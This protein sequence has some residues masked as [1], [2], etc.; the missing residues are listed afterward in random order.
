MQYTWL[1]ITLQKNTVGLV[2]K[3]SCLYLQLYQWIS[4]YTYTLYLQIVLLCRPPKSISR[5]K[6][7]PVH[8]EDK[9][10]NSASSSISATTTGI[11]D[12]LS[13]VKLLQKE[14]TKQL[15]VSCLATTN[16]IHHHCY[17]FS[18]TSHASLGVG[19]TDKVGNYNCV[20]K[21]V[22]SPYICVFRTFCCSRQPHW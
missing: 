5:S 19:A 20:F 13:R 21:I 16:E 6:L 18:Q 4:I 3:R 17:C 7:D 8:H 15:D 14:V 12:A 11:D 1:T 2:D 10:E 9:E 22:I